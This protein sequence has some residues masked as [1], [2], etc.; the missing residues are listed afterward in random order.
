MAYCII[1]LFI[2]VVLFT[3]FYLIPKVSQNGPNQPVTKLFSKKDWL[4]CGIITISYAMFSFYHIG[5]FKQDP[6]WYGD[7]KLKEINIIFKQ[8]SKVSNITLDACYDNSSLTNVYG[9]SADGKTIAFAVLKITKGFEPKCGIITLKNEESS[10]PLNRLKLKVLNPTMVINEIFIFNAD[11]PIYNYSYYYD[12]DKNLDNPVGIFATNTYESQIATNFGK[13]VFDEKYYALDSYHYII[14]NSEI[15]QAHPQLAILI[16][17]IGIELFGMNPFGWR[18]IPNVFGILLLP[19]VYCFAK[20]L[21]RNST[22]AAL[23]A[24]FVSIDFMHFTI[25][26]MAMLESVVTFFIIYSYYLLWQY[27]IYS[28]LNVMKSNKSLF[29]C[30]L[31]V[32]VATACKW[33]GGFILPLLLIVVGT[34]GWQKPKRCWSFLLLTLSLVVVP[35]LIYIISYFPFLLMNKFSIW[36]NF[37][38]LQKTAFI[39][40]S[41]LAV[42][43]ENSGDTS[44]WWRWP[45][46][47]DILLMD[48]KL[49]YITSKSFSLVLM[50]NPILWWSSIPIVVTLIIANIKKLNKS[51]LFIM[52]AIFVQMFPYMIAKRE[53]YIYYYYSISIFIFVALGY[54][55]HQLWLLRRRSNLYGVI[56]LGYVFIALLA[57]VAYYPIYAGS[58]INFTYVYNNLSWLPSWHFLI[59][60][61]H[62]IVTH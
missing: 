46:D 9:L 49:N 16:N 51:T 45:L 56:A 60:P 11:A 21:F 34:V 35:S 38:Q 50:G 7:T 17:A 8:S 48:F 54:F 37:I 4:I 20:Q 57:F 43:G 33:S 53:M 40:H 3:R 30:G 22:V 41:K 62:F 61:P 5:S 1:V 32:G 31:M 6:V 2:V 47:L 39:I 23:S 59:L 55:I 44:H 29:Y 26:R 27:Y 14:K 28:S 25:S 13:M 15:N 58:V 36:H 10:V 12:S 42:I 52:L 24:F 19:L 18:F